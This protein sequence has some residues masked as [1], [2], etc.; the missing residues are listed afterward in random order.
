VTRPIDPEKRAGRLAPVRLEVLYD[1][2]RYDPSRTLLLLIAA[3]E[4]R[5]MK[6]DGTY[7]SPG[8]GEEYVGVWVGTVHRDRIISTLGI[9]PARWRAAV[10]QWVGFGLA[11]R[12]K[13]GAVF[14]LTRAGAACPRCTGNVA[15]RDDAASPTATVDVA[16]SDVIRHE[17]GERPG[18]GVLR[19]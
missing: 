10:T 3:A 15:H 16:L 5:S 11:H 4:G 14:L 12:C 19:G 18:R 9:K 6:A 1:L 7:D 8:F 2:Y 17:Q 13:P